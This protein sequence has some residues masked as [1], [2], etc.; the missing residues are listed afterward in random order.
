MFSYSS[1]LGKTPTSKVISILAILYFG[2]MYGSCFISPELFE[3]FMAESLNSTNIG[4]YEATSNLSMLG[5]WWSGPKECPSTLVKNMLPEGY[6]NQ[7]HTVTS[8]DGYIL[9]LFRILKSDEAEEQGGEA[10][11]VV[12]VQHGL[13]NDGTTF[14][15]NGEKSLVIQLVDAGFD[16][17]LGNNR[18]SRF[19]RKHVKLSPESKEFWNFSF[20]EMGEQD[21]PAFFRYIIETTGQDKIRYI[22][23]SQGTTQMFAALSDPV[24]R[25]KIAPHVE[26]FYALAPVVYLNDN[27][28]P[29]PN[30]AAYLT[31]IVRIV[32]NVLRVNYLALGT[33]LWSQPEVEKINK[34]CSE[35]YKGCYKAYSWYDQEP[36][37]LN[38]PRAGYLSM[39]SPSGSS[40][41]C[42]L[43]YGQLVERQNSDQWYFAKYDYGNQAQ[44]MKKYGQKTA[45]SY[46][47]SLIQE[48][49]RMWVGSADGIVTPPEAMRI[50]VRAFNADIG[51]KVLTDWGHSS[52]HL[53]VNSEFY[54]TELVEALKSGKY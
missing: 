29:I 31:N 43:H 24:T 40:T 11:P 35:H 1:Y 7:P 28:L 6:E 46:D 42:L 13:Q 16:V 9:T 51:I 47:L 20:D 33:C 30:F 15:Q 53:A 23:H 3:T 26:V 14:L 27:K 25:P 32:K 5:S 52:F 50:Q 54:Y 18:G 17:W 4:S 34:Q 8:D 22:G 41:D 2:S 45:P 36:S 38:W 37:V 39:S 49:V 44:N 19:S 10:K 21:L 12:L 48:T